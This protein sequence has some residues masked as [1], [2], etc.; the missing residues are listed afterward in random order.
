MH[1]YEIN[2]TLETEASMFPQGCCVLKNLR[3]LQTLVEMIVGVII[4]GTPT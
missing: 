4:G 1:A 3:S 2:D